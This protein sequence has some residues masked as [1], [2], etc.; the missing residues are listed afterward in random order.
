MIRKKC[1]MNT[2][3]A[4]AKTDRSLAVSSA[5]KTPEDATSLTEIFGRF[6]RLYVAE[7]DA[8]PATIRT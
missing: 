8:S 3:K 4:I 5:P 7:G 6:L 2:S 1:D